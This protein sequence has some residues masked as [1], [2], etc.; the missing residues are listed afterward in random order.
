[1][2][3]LDSEAINAMKVGGQRFCDEAIKMWTTGQY[4][5]IPQEQR[6]KFQKQWQEIRNRIGVLC[7]GN[8]III[9]D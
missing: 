7:N 1:M 4:A 9:K 2:E 5:D 3:D 8:N 6:Q